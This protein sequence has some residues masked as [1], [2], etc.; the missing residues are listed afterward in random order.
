MFGDL[1]ADELGGDEDDDFSGE[2]DARFDFDKSSAH[3]PWGFE[4]SAQEDAL[5]TYWLQEAYLKTDY[6]GDGIAELR[7]VCLVGRKVLATA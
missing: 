2:R 5:R 7:K 3:S 4:S 1:D 6:D